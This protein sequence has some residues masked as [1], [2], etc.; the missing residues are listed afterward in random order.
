MRVRHLL[1]AAG[2]VLSAI[3]L[4][5]LVLGHSQ[6]PQQPHRG[7]VRSEPL[8]DAKPGNTLLDVGDESSHRKHVVSAVPITVVDVRGSPIPLALPYFT[9]PN[10]RYVDESHLDIACHLDN[11][12][13]GFILERDVAHAHNESKF[14]VVYSPRHLPWSTSAGNLLQWVGSSTSLRIE[15]VPTP[16]QIARFSDTHGKPVPEQTIRYYRHGELP[17]ELGSSALPGS[18]KDPVFSAVSDST[19]TASVGL[20]AA[21]YAF[22]VGPHNVMAVAALSPG[23]PAQLPGPAICVTLHEVYVA[24]CV[25][26]GDVCVTYAAEVVGAS[27]A[28]HG[29]KQLPIVRGRELAKL[30]ADCPQGTAL[31]WAALPKPRAQVHHVRLTL[32]LER[33]GWTTVEVPFRP[34]TDRGQPTIIEM[35]PHAPIAAGG[36]LEIAWDRPGPMP[37]YVLRGKP[38]PPGVMPMELS[39]RSPRTVRLPPGDY[40]IEPEDRSSR[41]LAGQTRVTVVADAAVRLGLK[42]PDGAVLCKLGGKTAGGSPAIQTNIALWQSDGKRWGYLVPEDRD[43]PVFIPSGKLRVRA[44]ALNCTPVLMDLVAQEGSSLVELTVVF[45]EGE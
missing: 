33:T 36:L 6:D 3:L 45:P 14:L 21:S 13:Q 12:G 22:R 40:A 5:V 29:M 19:G 38:A 23:S 34:I 35:S 43:N 30:Q 4:A 28:N 2:V 9:P 39:I 20:P 1:L 17:N 16:M 37:A 7:L 42:P 8:A 15:L 18:S 26:R 24:R 10:T 41:L 25:I 32:L 11:D 27:L 44:T 31:V